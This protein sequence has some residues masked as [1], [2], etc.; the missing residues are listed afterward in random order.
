MRTSGHVAQRP[1]HGAVALEPAAKCNLPHAVAAAHE[2]VMLTVREL[3]PNARAACVAELLERLSARI[4]HR[5]AQMQLLLNRVNHGSAASVNAEVVECQAEI[6]N[7]WLAGVVL[8]RRKLS[9][10]LKA[11]KAL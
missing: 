7:V 11:E 10:S 5:I 2:P 8:V 1:P 3:V 6:R 4:D 9:S